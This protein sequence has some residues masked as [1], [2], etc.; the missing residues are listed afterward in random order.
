M[1]DGTKGLGTGGLLMPLL[2]ALY[3]LVDRSVKDAFAFF[4]PVLLLHL[5]QYFF[6]VLG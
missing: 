3:A 1:G 6:A 2:A 4:F 5:G